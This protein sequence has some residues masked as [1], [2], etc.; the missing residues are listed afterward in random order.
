MGEL[1]AALGRRRALASGAI[2]ASRVPFATSLEGRQV[3]LFLGTGQDA[4]NLTR[5]R[6]HGVTH[7]LNVA[8]D[9]E[10]FHPQHF[11]YCNLNAH[12]RNAMFLGLSALLHIISLAS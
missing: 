2:W 1:A 4:A 9:V 5:L 10:N 6:Q 7:I 11:T 8:D 3:S 12:R